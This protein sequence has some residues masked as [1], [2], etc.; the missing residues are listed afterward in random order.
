MR[1]LLILGA[2]ILW[3]ILRDDSGSNKTMTT[4]LDFITKLR[5][6]ALAVKSELGFHHDLGMLQAAHE[7]A[8]GSSA[9]SNPASILEI[10]V[11]PTNDS[12]VVRTGAA[13]N[14]FGFTAEPDTYWRNPKSASGNRE[15]VMMPTLEWV[16]PDKVLPTDV[17]TSAPPDPKTGKVEVKRKR[18]FRAYKSWDESY[19]DWARLMSIPAY[20][21][22]GAPAALKAGDLKA[23]AAALA[24]VGYATDPR[25]VA[26]L[27]KMDRGA[28]A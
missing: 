28:F 10:R 1:P 17:R 4:K 18:P 24:K 14:L 13:F 9:L 26:K 5:P 27:E 3:K 12:P 21:N 15:F 8:Y 11:G 25:Y 20:V 2:L 23:F 19:R 7:S 22:A 16:A 6:T